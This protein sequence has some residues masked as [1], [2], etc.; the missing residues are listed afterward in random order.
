MFD[1]ERWLSQLTVPVTD[2]MPLI[3]PIL[4]S[5]SSPAAV[6]GPSVRPG[7]PAGARRTER[8]LSRWRRRGLAKITAS[9]GTRLL[10]HQ[11]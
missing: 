4:L 9:A 1:T 6:K 7:P 2:I 11:R 10:Q 3:C 8:S 5:T